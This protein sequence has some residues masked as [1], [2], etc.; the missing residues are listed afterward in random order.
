[1]H[2]YRVFVSYSR[3]DREMVENLVIS[4]ERS[5]LRPVWDRDIRPGD[6]FSEVI[7][8]GISHAHVFIPVLTRKGVKRPWVHQETGYAMGLEVPVLPIAVGQVPKQM[9]ADLHALEVSPELTDLVGEVLAEA[10]ES[11]LNREPQESEATFRAAPL[12]EMRA[13]LLARYTR[14]AT[15]LNPFGHAF[16][17][18]RQAGALSSFCLPKDPPDHPVWVLRDGRLP[19]SKFLYERLQKER[20]AFEE[21]VRGHGCDLILDPSIPFEQNGPEARKQRLTTL[22]EFLK[23]ESIQNVQVAIR[24]RQAAGSLTI[25]GD[26]FSAESIAPRPG[27]GYWGTI[28]SWHAPT[29]LRRLHE[30]ESDFARILESSGVNGAASREAAI[31]VVEEQLAATE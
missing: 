22:L 20:L 29:V 31:R 25:C 3:E 2:P 7:K 9:I 13:E 4:M 21:Y 30:F 28:F 14:Q 17:P 1:M 18:M 26:W 27:E 15:K 5:G 16:G 10:I 12:P 19:R 11:L 23:D 24:P 6:P 8:H